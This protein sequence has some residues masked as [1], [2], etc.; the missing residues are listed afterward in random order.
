MN[1]D[2]VSNIP[3]IGITL[4]FPS[5][6][7]C[8][9]NNGL[10]QNALFFYKLLLN[11]GKYDV[12]FIVDKNSSEGE[13]YLDKMNYRYIKQESII[14]SCFNI[15]ITFGFCLPSNICVS[16]KEKGIKQIFYN[17]GNFFICDSE[18]CLFAR[19]ESFYSMYTRFQY[20]D[21]CW[22]I[23]QM[24]NTNH[25][26]LKTLLRCNKVIEV[27]F[28]WSPEL[29]DN[30]TNKYIKRS[31]CKSIAI[32]EPN[33]S[34]MKWCFPPILI[35]EN[36]YRDTT[37]TNKIN[38]VYITNILET[39]NKT[40]NL[41]NFNNLVS[42]LD[43]K[44]DSKL[45]IEKRYMSLSFM[46]K[47]TDI[48]VSHT[49]ENHLNNLYFD[50]AWMGWPIIHNG[51]FCKEVGY[52]YDEFNYEMGGNVLKDAILNHDNNADEYLIRN[53]KYMQKYLPSNIN[54][55]KKY[56]DLIIDCLM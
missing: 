18:T 22:N 19:E 53:R 27:P 52:Y 16:L 38:K 56:E 11:I 21:E 54:L 35:C 9:F 45:S 5:G 31:E 23:P 41:Q 28:I 33:L 49:W 32:F 14:D 40:F 26:Y 8:L 39:S 34:I 37:I 25:Y 17:C 3:K 29:I 47:Y 36:A 15:V 46:A 12:Y 24:E 55:Q 2:S 48:V 13:K 10:R 50:I 4:T 44:K 43:L 51:K 20:F 42:C 7:G 6:E 30:E 1:S